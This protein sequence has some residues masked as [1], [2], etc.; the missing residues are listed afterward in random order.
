MRVSEWKRKINVQENKKTFEKNS[1]PEE[2]SRYERNKTCGNSGGF[3]E[4]S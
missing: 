4:E 3:A 2:I 1:L